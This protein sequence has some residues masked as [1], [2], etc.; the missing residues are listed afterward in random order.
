MSI[1]HT[2]P[3]TYILRNLHDIAIPESV[4]WF[5]QTIGWKMVGCA[6]LLVALYFAYGMVRHWWTNRYRQEAVYALKSIDPQ[7][8]KAAERAF[9]ILKVVLRHLD[10]RN[11]RLFGQPCLN[12]LDA[13]R[14]SN[15]KASPLFTDALSQRWMQSLI[16]PKTELTRDQRVEV[17]NKSLEWIK[18]HR[19][20]VVL[21]STEK[22]NA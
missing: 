1:E 2:P 6:L 17:I 13:Y 11:A 19:T 4:R 20:S 7:E 5:P 16:D 15:K 12:Q 14:T 3:S 22:G 10:S 9:K 21:S 18:S 8:K